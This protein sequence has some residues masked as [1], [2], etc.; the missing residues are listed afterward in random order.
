[1]LSAFPDARLN[2]ELKED[3]GPLPDR[4]LDL[5]EAGDRAER[6]LLTAEKD[7]LMARLR[8]RVAARGTPVALGAC[9][10]EVASF[11]RA[12]SGAGE[13]DAGPMALQIPDRFGDRPLVTP[14]LLA[15]AHGRGVAVHV[16]TIN[17]PSE[18]ARLLGLGVDG[19]VSDFPARVV[20]ARETLR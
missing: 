2:L 1:M 19:I 9:V 14:E 20:A 13:P 16:W 15:F 8:E 10:S 17:E 7:A 18:I 4:C 3:Q 5:L 6:V 12:A 11:A